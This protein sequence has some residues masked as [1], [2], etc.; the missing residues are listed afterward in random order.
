MMG[1]RCRFVLVMLSSTLYCSSLL[2]PC[3][4]LT[5]FL[6]VWFILVFLFVLGFFVLF[7][8]VVDCVPCED[9]IEKGS[10]QPAVAE[11]VLAHCRTRRP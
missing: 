9:E 8:F 10:E 3:N 5:N 4:V 7:C 1:P 6:F 2:K 11:N